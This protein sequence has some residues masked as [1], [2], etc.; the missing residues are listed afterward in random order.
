[1]HSPPA[2]VAL[3][4]QQAPNWRAS[5]VSR[6]QRSLPRHAPLRPGP[7]AAVLAAACSVPQRRPAPPCRAG[8]SHR[9][10]HRGER[11]LADGPGTGGPGLHTGG[12]GCAPRRRLAGGTA[13]RAAVGCW[14][15][16]GTHPGPAALPWP[17]G[18]LAHAAPG[19]PPC[20]GRPQAELPHLHEPHLQRA[21]VARG[22]GAVLQGEPGGGGRERPSLFSARPAASPARLQRSVPGMSP[23]TPPVPQPRW[24]L[25]RR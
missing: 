10:A 11:G 16:G 6:L 1:M 3:A 17:L 19:P 5:V 9:R 22:H 7:P 21:V 2:S 4:A 12:H 20:R 24:P 23:F 18:P 13:A 25:C 15:A 8:P 14:H